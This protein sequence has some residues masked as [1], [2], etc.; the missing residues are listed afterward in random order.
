MRSIM[1]TVIDKDKTKGLVTIQTVDGGVI[2]MKVFKQQFARYSHVIS[3][4][5]ED[6]NKDILED[7]FFDKGVHLFVTGI[8]RGDVFVPKVYRSTGFDAILRVV[9]NEDGSFRTLLRKME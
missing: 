6:G 2:D 5:D 8:L 9:L 1:G 7:S 4:E 3:Q